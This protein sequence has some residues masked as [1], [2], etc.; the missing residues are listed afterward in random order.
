M[1][2]HGKGVVQ[3]LQK[4]ILWFHKAAD[5]GDANA[6]YILG[7]LYKKG[8]GVTQDLEKAMHWFRKAS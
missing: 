7:I 1:Y 5:Q 3:D 6:Q 4:A 2:F 8:E